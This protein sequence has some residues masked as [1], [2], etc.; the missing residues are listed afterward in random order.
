MTIESDAEDLEAWADAVRVNPAALEAIGNGRRRSVEL[1]RSLTSIIDAAMARA[2]EAAQS[3]D[4]FRGSMIVA[5][6]RRVRDGNAELFRKL[7]AGEPVTAAQYNALWSSLLS[8][9]ANMGDSL[10]NDDA[11]R[12]TVHTNIPG[13]DAVRLPTARGERRAPAA[14][15]SSPAAPAALSSGAGGFFVVLGLAG[16]AAGAAAASRSRRARA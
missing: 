3:G 6:A 12:Q 15:A 5:M 16:L 13:G 1:L 2:R 8:V 11:A 9:T 14:P 4:P 7:A 10:P